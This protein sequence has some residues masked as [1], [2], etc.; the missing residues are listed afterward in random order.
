VAHRLVF[1]QT[2]TE[3][4]PSQYRLRYR[5]AGLIPWSGDSIDP[6]E[7]YLKIQNEYL[8]I[9]GDEYD[10]EVRVNASIGYKFAD[11]NKL[12]FGLAGRL[13]NLINNPVRSATWITLGGFLVI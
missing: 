4:S 9:Y 1:D 11:S 2:I 8:K 6:T 3:A 12:E 13:E 5:L 10:L 7:F